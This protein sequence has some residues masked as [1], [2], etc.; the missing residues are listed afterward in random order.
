MAIKFNKNAKV[1]NQ[2]VSTNESTIDS[3][4]QVGQYLRNGNNSLFHIG[5]ITPTQVV[6]QLMD[7]TN[8]KTLYLSRKVFVQL[9]YRKNYDQVKDPKN[10]IKEWVT[11][12][13][14]GATRFLI[15]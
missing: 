4:I 8:P 14:V 10:Y 5:A 7:P 1:V 2:I 15:K 11:A 13:S 3:T 12:K 6:L 9:Y